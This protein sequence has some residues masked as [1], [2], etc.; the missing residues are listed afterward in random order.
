MY[1]AEITLGIIKLED[2][3]ILHSDW[4]QSTAERQK[5]HNVPVPIQE[6]P[7]EKRRHSDSHKLH[8]NWIQNMYLF[9][10][11]IAGGIHVVPLL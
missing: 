3:Q 6:S 9:P 10:F 11:L 7:K 5:T 8:I 4:I 1:E 2:L